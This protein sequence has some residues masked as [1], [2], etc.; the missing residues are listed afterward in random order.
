MAL[1]LAGDLTLYAVLPA[2]AAELA[3]SLAAV[4]ILLS[5]NRLVRLIS[6][7]LVGL[8]A[9]RFTRRRLVLTGLTTGLLSTLL[10]VVANNLW[11][12]LLGRLL[13]GISWSIIY[14]GIFCIILDITGLEDRGWGS[15]L[16]QTFY[17][18]GLAITPLLGGLFSSWFGF[19]QALLLCA[20]LQGAGLLTVLAFLPETFNPDLENLP[21][22]SFADWIEKARSKLK[23]ISAVWFR[24]NREVLTANYLYMVTLFV[25]DGIIMSTITLY[26]KE[27]Y[28]NTMQVGQ[29]VVP[30]A[31][32]GGVLLAMRAV[33]SAGAAPWTGHWSDR[34]RN[35]WMA[36]RW[37]AWVTITGCWLLVPERN[38]SLMVA[39]VALAAFGSGMVMA[40]LPAVVSSAAGRQGEFAMGVLATSGDIGCAIAPLFGYLLLECVSLSALYLISGGL[41][42]TGALASLLV[43]RS[44]ARSTQTVDTR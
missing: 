2:Y 35:R 27:R 29:V 20:V 37:G 25:G 19:S 22:F 43:V 31:I 40:V 16:L 30:V 38:F 11:V 7:P 1:S 24:Q 17:F 14:I 4:G 34:S 39:G 32:M 15:G 23:I 42:V 18:V 44:G 8:L 26:L 28:G 5:A 33:I 36:A 6:N 10:Y 13:W 12:F 21:R 9:N 3:I 41:L